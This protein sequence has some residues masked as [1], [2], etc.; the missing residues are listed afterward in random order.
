MLP[1]L[2][3]YML[4]HGDFFPGNLFVDVVGNVTVLLLCTELACRTIDSRY[5][6]NGPVAPGAIS[7]PT[8]VGRCGAIHRHDAEYL[9]RVAV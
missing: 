6:A 1:Y 2:G 5:R 4:S 8:Q 7:G 9:D 3:Q